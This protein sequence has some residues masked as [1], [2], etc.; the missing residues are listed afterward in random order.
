MS[1]YPLS[2]TYIVIYLLFYKKFFFFPGRTSILALFELFV[3]PECTSQVTLKFCKEK[4]KK[5]K[6]KK[7]NLSHVSSVCI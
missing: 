5:K 6:K 4:K 3:Q 2:Y 1:F 7:K